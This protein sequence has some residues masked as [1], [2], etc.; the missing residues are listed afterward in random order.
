MPR[1]E[2]FA[3]D[4]DSAYVREPSYFAGMPR[5]APERVPEIRGA[6]ASRCSATA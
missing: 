6:R 3:W 1:G 5:E 2:R 4:P